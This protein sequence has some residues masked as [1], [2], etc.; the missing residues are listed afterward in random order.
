MTPQAR[1][2]WDERFTD[3]DFGSDHPMNPL[4]LDLTARLCRE[5]GLFDAGDTGTDVEVVGV[6]VPDDDVLLRVHTP[7]YIAAVKEAS[8]D[9]GSARTAFGLGTDDDPAF[10]GIHETSA[11]IAG[12]TLDVAQAV[13]TGTAGHGVNF[14]GGLHH[15]MAGHAAGFCIYNDASVAI[16][17]LLEHGAQRVAYVDV[18]A[19]HGDGVERMFWND[20]RVMTISLHETG[21]VLFPGT[22]FAGDIGG[23]AALGTAANLA[24]PPGIND[25][26]WLRGFH[27]IVPPLLRVFRPEILITQHG[28]DSHF[29]DP[30]AHLAISVDAQKLVAEALHDLAHELCQG[31]WVALGGGGYEIVGVV[32]RSWTHLTAI[33]AH[34]PI[35]LL[36]PIPA[37]WLEHVAGI[38]GRSG[39]D[40][41]RT[42]GDGTADDG[43]IWF[44]SWDAGFD[45]DNAI[46]RTVMAKREAT[47]SHHGLDAW[48]D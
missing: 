47:F 13:W 6:E 43:R 4:R 20:P 14:T 40:V 24:L 33:A 45:P 28:A 2:I 1:V 26:G 41:P 8:A 16:S 31:R 38:S 22:G 25:V 42:M 44:R 7:E 29:S 19:H 11:R 48:F 27:A 17:W 37:R 21:T 3:Y 15:A 12:A 36:T 23:P 10:A 5:F 18:D 46:D 30:L 32:P 9:P 39:S 34:R 35:D